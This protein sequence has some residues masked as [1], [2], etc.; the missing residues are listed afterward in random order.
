MGF[1]GAFAVG[2]C[3]LLRRGYRWI[4]A[5]MT[6]G[7]LWALIPD[8]PG[9][10]REDIPE[11]PLAWLIGHP[12]IDGLLNDWGNLFF[13]HRT[14]DAQ[15]DAHA[16]LGLTIIILL[17]N[18]AIAGLLWSMSGPRTSH[19]HRDDEIRHSPADLEPLRKRD[20]PPH[21]LTLDRSDPVIHRISPE[22]A[23]KKA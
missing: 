12:A 2:L 21:V 8:L 3:M 5:A 1:A 22:Q 13:F 20:E 14:L 10:F 9:V 7:G 16:L 23:D 11:A 17:Y 4:P 19:S 18:A 15:G 6:G